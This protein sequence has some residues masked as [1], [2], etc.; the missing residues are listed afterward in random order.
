MK[1]KKIKTL[2]ILK[3]TRFLKYKDTNTFVEFF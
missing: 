1:Y 3:A 2:N